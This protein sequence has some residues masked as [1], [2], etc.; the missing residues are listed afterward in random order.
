MYQEISVHYLE[1]SQSQCKV[2]I[3]ILILENKNWWWEHIVISSKLQ[4]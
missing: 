1:C 3:M 2:D 4:Y